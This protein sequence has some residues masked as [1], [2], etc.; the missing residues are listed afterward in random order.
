MRAKSH[1]QLVSRQSFPAFH[2]HVR[3]KRIRYET[4]E[5][6]D[7]CLLTP[8]IFS[9]FVWLLIVVTFVD[10]GPR[11]TQ[12]R[13]PISAKLVANMLSVSGADHIIT[14]DLHASQIQGED[15]IPHPPL[16]S[17]SDTCMRG[18]SSPTS[19]D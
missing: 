8:L 19:D 5:P 14:M 2:M 13:A 1:Q 16:I 15:I 4:P 10:A 9:S 3:T 7:S 12:S 6:T 11:D 18:N 17:L